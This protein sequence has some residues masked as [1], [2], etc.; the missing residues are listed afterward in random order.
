M[1]LSHYFIHRVRISALLVSF[2]FLGM[3]LSIQAVDPGAAQDAE[4]AREKLLKAEDQLELIQSNSET[5]KIAVDGMKAD[6]LKLQADMASTRAENAALKQQLADLQAAFDKSETA[7]VKERQVLLDEVAKLV[8]SGKSSTPA[9]PAAK[10]KE[11][12]TTSPLAPPPE[13]EHTAGTT[14][15]PSTAASSS[16]SGPANTSSTGTNTPPPPPV[17]A[18]KGYYHVVA[19]G[20]TITVICTAFREQGVNV[21]VAEIRKANGLTE[22][23]V[24]KV[25]QKLFIPKPGI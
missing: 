19:S 16:T 15:S 5:T 13:P 24:L 3:P 20:E 23:S 11:S 7:R 6:V 4:A 17:K 1:K 22:K 9:K 21:T 8:A 18:Q 2:V 14:P 12:A 25:G 10:K